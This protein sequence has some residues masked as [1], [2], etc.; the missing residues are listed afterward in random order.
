MQGRG[1]GKGG[2]KGERGR[3]KRGEGAEWEGS[4]AKAKAR[5]AFEE[6]LVDRG[7]VR[8]SRDSILSRLDTLAARYSRG[9]ILSRLDIVGMRYLAGLVEPDIGHRRKHP[10][11]GA[12][13]RTW[14]SG[15]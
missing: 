13:N 2:E 12:K 7:G 14:R 10:K 1:R 9:S 11:R 8:Y 6:G 5:D 15:N 4:E 3:E